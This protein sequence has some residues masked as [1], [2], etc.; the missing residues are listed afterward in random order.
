MTYG[1][2]EGAGQ[3]VQDRLPLSPARYGWGLPFPVQAGC[4]MHLH[5]LPEQGRKILMDRESHDLTGEPMIPNT[6]R[7]KA[8]ASL[9]AAA[10]FFVLCLAAYFLVDG[11]S[12]G[13][14]LAF[15]SFFLAV[16][17]VAIALFYASRARAM[18][19]ILA[20][21]LPLA[22]WTYPAGMARAAVEREYR[23]FRE[24]N[25]VMF[26]VIG[27]MLVVAAVVMALVAGD[28]GRETGLFLIAVMAF[29]YVVSRVTPWLERRRALNTPHDAVISPVGIVYEG[30]VYPFR[31][32]LVFRDG[33]SLRKA[34]NRNPAAL[35]FSFTQAAGAFIVQPFDVV[36]PVP[37]GE[38]ERAE[39]II[40]Q[41]CGNSAE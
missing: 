39:W 36:V 21:P 22:H 27:G 19:A 10:V 37:P 26:L 5:P 14:A 12:G 15:V 35:V 7:K 23:E 20:D 29:L 31:S 9:I 40:G 17:G 2:A 3:S 41:L 6:E 33:I 30:A 11:M 34:D 18:D 32:F 38:E 1:A 13:Y 4:G 25:R 28:G 24:R 8:A 16:C